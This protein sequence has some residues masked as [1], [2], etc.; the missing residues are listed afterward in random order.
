MSM[1]PLSSSTSTS[2]NDIFN[3]RNRLERFRGLDD[4][5]NRLI[6]EALENLEQ[7]TR[8]LDYVTSVRMPEQEAHFLAQIHE[9]K[10]DLQDQTDSRRRYQAKADQI[11]YKLSVMDK[12]R[13]VSVLIDADADIYY[14]TNDLLSQGLKGG[15]LAA[16]MLIEKVKEHL[17]S[18]G[19]SFR[20][21]TTIPIM[22]KAYANLSGLTYHLRDIASPKELSQFWIGFSQRSPF[23]DFVDVGSGKEAADNK[24]REVL[25][26]NIDSPQCEHIFLACSHDGGYV[27]V[28]SPHA[29]RASGS[30]MRITLV[31]SG[32]GSVHPLIADLGF[33]ETDIFKPLFSQSESQRVV[34]WAKSTTKPIEAPAPPSRTSTAPVVIPSEAPKALTWSTK[35]KLSP[36][37]TQAV[38]AVSS[39][40]VTSNQPP[41]QKKSA[42][43]EYPYNPERI[44]FTGEYFVANAGRLIPEK[45]DEGYRI[46]DNKLIVDPRTDSDLIGKMKD[47]NIC[48]W[49]YLRSDHNIPQC[50]RKHDGYPRPLSPKEY[51]ALWFLARL[52]YCKKMKTDGYCTDDYCIY[53][54][55]SKYSYN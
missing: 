18:L 29:G 41:T 8:Q 47:K 50:K 16:D 51:D 3:Y 12:A 44:D 30:K 55:D 17:V 20:D 31:S 28:L 7:A 25:R 48:S 33:R 10:V 19:P 23:I 52:G 4:E 42:T 13:F 1:V 15:Q 38:P 43:P 54:H 11:D 34:D 24:I 36:S 6:E 35:A 53:G 9:L 32:P 37:T 40:S 49:H 46:K 27:P 45:D 39:A 5:R 22:V 14:F 21:P 26:F 2:G